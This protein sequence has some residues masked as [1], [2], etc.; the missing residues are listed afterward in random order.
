MTHHTPQMM[1]ARPDL[2]TNTNQPIKRHLY[3]HQLAAAPIIFAVSR[4]HTGGSKTQDVLNT[5]RLCVSENR[6][7]RHYKTL[8][9][10]WQIATHF[11]HHPQS[12]RAFLFW[13]ISEHCLGLP[14]ILGYRHTRNH[15]KGGQSRR[16]NHNAWPTALS[17]LLSLILTVATL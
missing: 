12:G 13:D 1:H 10:C 8:Q 4:H 9:H 2:A 15:H 11:V 14:S 16:R 7:W 3:L 6:M 5:C 17:N